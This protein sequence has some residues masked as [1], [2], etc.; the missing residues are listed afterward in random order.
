[1]GIIFH[2]LFENEIRKGKEALI[3]ILFM[4]IKENSIEK[5]EETQICMRGK[6]S[7]F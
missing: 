1:M 6:F 7:K 2:L 5:G 3:G 4:K